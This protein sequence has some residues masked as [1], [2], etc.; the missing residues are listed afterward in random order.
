MS[1]RLESKNGKVL[2]ET[3]NGQWAAC[4]ALARAF[5]ED[6][7]AWNGCHDGQV[8]TP[9]HL[10]KIAARIKQLQAF[11]FPDTLVELADNGGTTIQ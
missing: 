11:E 6:V 10:R 5:G 1:V 2:T 3:S 7:P 9:E 4:V 8:Y